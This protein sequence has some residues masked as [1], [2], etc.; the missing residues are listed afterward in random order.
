MLG[1]LNEYYKGMPIHIEEN[2]RYIRKKTSNIKTLDKIYE[3]VFG[4]DKIVD[5]WLEDGKM[6]AINGI[7]YMNGNT[8]RN[9]KMELEK[10]S[11]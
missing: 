9:L 6:I 2:V 3:I 11:I 10:S 7:L 4:Y 5:S 8:Y 1:L